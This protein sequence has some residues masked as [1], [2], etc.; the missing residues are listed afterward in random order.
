MNGRPENE[1]ASRPAPRRGDRPAFSEAGAWDAIGEGWRPLHGGF[2][3][4]GYSIEWHDF[5]AE[6]DLDWSRSFHPRGVEVC[7]NLCGHGSVQAGEEKIDF[8]PGTAGFYFQGARKLEA[9]RTGRERHQFVTVEFSFEFLDRQVG[10]ARTG[11]HPLLH[12]LFHGGGRKSSSVSTSVTLTTEHQQMIM[13]L[14]RPPVA[15][16]GRGLWSRAKALEV[17]A[18]FFFEPAAKADELFCERQERLDRERVQKVIGILKEN[19]ETP[20]SLEEMGKRVCCSHFHL[21]RTFT[22]VMGVT[23]SAHLRSLRMERAATLLREGKMNVTEVALVVGYSSLSH[24]STTFH[25]TYGCCPGLYP[26][27]TLPQRLARESGA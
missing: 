27:N 2:H 14:R 26:I 10:S 8:S 19:L 12:G 18:A 3:D 11:L 24:F 20:P 7:L 17:A 25:Q 22:R 21:S 4:E 5:H 6:R 1:T 13:S 9:R 15:M 23:I 16:A